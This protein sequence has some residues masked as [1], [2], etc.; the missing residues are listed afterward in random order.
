[1]KT[2]G[3]DWQQSGAVFCCKILLMKTNKTRKDYTSNGS[4]INWQFL[5]ITV[6]QTLAKGTACKIGYST[7][8]ALTALRLRGKIMP[9]KHKEAV[10]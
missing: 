7:G 9:S 1:M 4:H 3:G 6:K 10:E 8:T 5:W 2:K